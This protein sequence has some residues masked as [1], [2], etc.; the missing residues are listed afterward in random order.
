[1]HFTLMEKLIALELLSEAKTEQELIKALSKKEEFSEE[2]FRKALNHLKELEFI[3]EKEGKL[4][5]SKELLD[6]FK[7][8][9]EIEEKD[10]FRL[11]IHAFIE[12][13]AIERNLLEQQIEKIEEALKKEKDFTIYSLHKEEIIKLEENYSSFIDVVLSFKNFQALIKFILF[14]GPTSIEIIKPERIEFSAF[15]LQEGLLDLIGML[16]K[17]AAVTLKLMNRQELNEFYKKLL[18]K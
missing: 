7:K 10:S 6:E 13:Q 14:Y 17:Y 9:K 18:K 8:R 15:E 4:N 1:M 5:L 2:K 11:K 12:I 3:E 16:Q